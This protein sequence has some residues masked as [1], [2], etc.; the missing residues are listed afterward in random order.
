MFKSCFV[1]RVAAEKDRSVEL[2]CTFT[3]PTDSS[4]SA[5]SLP[6]AQALGSF[7]YPLG[8]S[9]VKPK[10][11][12]APEVTSLETYSCVSYVLHT[13]LTKTLSTPTIDDIVTYCRST[14]SP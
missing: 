9:N 5:Q 10:E 2:F 4:N 12:M 6:P 13:W 8:P 7:C 3:D 14:L 11:Y 1:A